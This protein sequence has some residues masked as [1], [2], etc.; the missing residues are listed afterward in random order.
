VILVFFFFNCL[1]V[2]TSRLREA[3]CP[4]LLKGDQMVGSLGVVVSPFRPTSRERCGDH[5]TTLRRRDVGAA[6]SFW[7]VWDLSDSLPSRVALSFQWVSGHARLPRN[8]RADSLA[9]TGATLPVTH[10]PCPLA[11]TIAKIRHT[12]YTLWKRNLFHNSLPSQ[13]PSVSSEE[14][15]RSLLIRW[16]LSQLR[17]HGHSLLLPMQDKT[18]EEFFLQFLQTPS[19]RS[20]SPSLLDCPAS[21]PLRRAILHYTSSIFDLWSKPWGVAP[22]LDLSGVHPRLIPRKVPPVVVHHHHC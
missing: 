12:R 7:D 6:K 5:T 18:K 3:G 13:V 8:E 1:N 2:A 17:C 22:L 15:A 9:K 4:R 16:E 10:V 19:A 11:P 14:L 20:N 21:E